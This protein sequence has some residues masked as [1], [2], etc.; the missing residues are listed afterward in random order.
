ME[1]ISVLV[2]SAPGSPA[3]QRAF[4]L[5]RNLAA[6][7]GQVSLCL[8]EDGVYAATGAAP[9]GACAAV[10]ALA[11]DL[12]LRG[13]AESDLTPACRPVSYGD[14]IDLVMTGSDRTLGTF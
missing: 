6:R 9:F 3:A 7:G 13:L 10:L 4:E 12:G 14:V 11:S 2:A 5:V 1:R 8:L